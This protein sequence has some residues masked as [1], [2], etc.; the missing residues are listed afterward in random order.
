MERRPLTH[1]LGPDPRIL[2]LVGGGARKMIGRNVADAVAAGLQRV[3]VD[4]G[5]RRQRIRRVLEPD[6]VELKILPGGEMA[7]AAIVLARDVGELAQ[8]AGRQ[9][10]VGNGDPQHVGMELQVKAVV[11]T[12]GLELLLRQFAGQPAAHLVAELL[13][14]LREQRAVEVVVVIEMG[15]R[16]NAPR[17]LQWPRR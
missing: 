7:I 17:R 2:D 8:L 14:P 11:Q 10:A 6:P 12:Q 4:L 3:H 5:Q 16:H 15:I 1:D 9:G 13:D